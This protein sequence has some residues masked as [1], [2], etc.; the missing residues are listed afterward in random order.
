M[1]YIWKQYLIFFSIGRVSDEE[2]CLSSSGS[3][4]NFLNFC[5]SAESL[6]PKYIQL[7]DYDDLEVCLLKHKTPFWPNSQILE[8]FMVDI[9]HY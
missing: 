7:V 9:L 3:P 4:G 5:P 2:H 1:G 8:V 6:T